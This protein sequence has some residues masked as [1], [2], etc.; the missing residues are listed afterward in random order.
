MESINTVERVL[1][2]LPHGRLVSTSVESQ[3]HWRGQKG[4]LHFDE[5]DP[6]LVDSV[7]MRGDNLFEFSHVKDDYSNLR[8][9]TSCAVDAET[10]RIII[11]PTGHRN[12]KL[13]IT[14][15]KDNFLY[16]VDHECKVRVAAIF[17]EEDGIEGVDLGWYTAV[18]FTGRGNGAFL[19]LERDE[20]LSFDVFPFVE[21]IGVPTVVTTSE[22]TTVVTNSVQEGRFVR[23]FDALGI[24]FVDENKMTP[25]RLPNGS[26]YP[27]DYMIYPDDPDYQAYVE[28]KPFRPTDVE[29]MKAG[30]L[31]R[32][33]GI[34]VY[35][36]WGEQFVPGLGVESDKWS[37]RGDMVRDA[38]YTS[39]IRGAK[40]FTNDEGDI[41]YEDG[42]YFMAND[43]AGGNEWVEECAAVE[44]EGTTAT[45]S[46]HVYRNKALARY[47][48]CGGRV[49][50]KKRRERFEMRPTIRS[51]SRVVTTS[52]R[53]FRPVDTFKAHLYRFK[54]FAINKPSTHIIPGPG[55]WNSERIQMAFRKAREV[56]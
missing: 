5:S 47:L 45:T 33:T 14:Q 3:V 2:L 1:E 22:G 4:I 53:R 35:I 56:S 44:R 20:E 52:G 25:I 17:S 30:E 31:H 54:P 10:G 6:K 12:S 8:R 34:D 21:R 28:V 29:I 18:E 24:P 37:S 16:S 42:Y 48:E 13:T 50:T 26:L 23:L 38:K 15:C 51:S 55:D 36:V 49:I 46:V 32:T 39:G 27:V 11:A 43:K 19:I 9:L 7:R 41:D 40:I